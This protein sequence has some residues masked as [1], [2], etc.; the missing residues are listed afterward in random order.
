MGDGPI[1][2]SRSVGEKEMALG[3]SVRRVKHLERDK[4]PGPG[5]D[6]RLMSSMTYIHIYTMEYPVVRRCKLP[7]HYESRLYPSPL[8]YSRAPHILLVAIAS[9]ASSC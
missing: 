2:G 9:A 3:G 7:T 5:Q 4:L 6:E 1:Q 8:L